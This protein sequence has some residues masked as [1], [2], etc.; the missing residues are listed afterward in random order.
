MRDVDSSDLSRMTKV[1]PETHA[2]MNSVL[3][4]RGRGNGLYALLDVGAGTTDLSF[5]WLQR[6]A[7]GEDRYWTYATGTLEQ[8]IDDVDRILCEAGHP[9]VVRKPGERDHLLAGISGG[10]GAGLHRLRRRLFRQFNQLMKESMDKDTESA[11]RSW[12]DGELAPAVLLVGGGSRCKAYRKPLEEEVP[13]VWQCSDW[14]HPL[15]YLQIPASPSVWIVGDS[16][17]RRHGNRFSG[18]S[19][20]HVIAHGLARRRVDIPEIHEVEGNEDSPP[21]IKSCPCHGKNDD[22]SRCGGLGWWT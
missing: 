10:P 18:I 5:L 9:P 20:L 17:G 8:G 4:Q 7:D 15:A 13:T 2:A 3:H 11:R 14:K 22:C 16:S 1:Y 19:D 12:L 21:N 6:A